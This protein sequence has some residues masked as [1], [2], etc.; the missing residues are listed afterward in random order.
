MGIPVLP[1]QRPPPAPAESLGSERRRLAHL[2]HHEEA[3]APVTLSAL[4]RRVVGN[5]Q[6]G[7]EAMRDEPLRRDACIV[8]RS[9]P[10]GG[11]RL[12]GPGL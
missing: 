6:R 11:A 2:G 4:G 10:F 5:G 8:Q 9:G 1:R 3:D 7:A 12:E